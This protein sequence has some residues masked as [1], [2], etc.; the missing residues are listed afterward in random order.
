MSV[1][2]KRLQA[3]YSKIMETFAA[4][5]KI[6]LKQTSGNPPEKYQ[7][8]YLINSLVMRPDGTVQM[9]NTHLVEIFLTRSYPR[10]A[11]QCRML[12][13]VF[14]PNIAPHAI[15][16]GD[17]WAAGESLS[18]LM[19]RIGEMLSFQS[20][21]LKSPLNGEAAKWVDQNRAR[22]PIDKYDFSGLMDAGE[23]VLSEK[24]VQTIS[25]ESQVQCSN[26]G[27][28]ISGSQSV[29]CVSKHVACKNCLVSCSLC[30]RQLCLKCLLNRCAVCGQ[31][32]CTQCHVKCGGCK[33]DLCT[34]HAQ[35]CHVCQISI[36]PDCAVECAMCGQATCMEHI[37]ADASGQYSCSRCLK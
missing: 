10:Q 4:G 13:P 27:V 37:K 21:N 18:H 22:L 30:G 12:T 15:C 2:L 25:A 28:Q 8:E 29:V 33:T 17:H 16:I 23:K 36:C 11:P 31:M 7:I 5:G 19:V 32:V 35:K 3:D 34:D 20:Y 6:Q 9:K 14:H 1:R 24:Q 26:C